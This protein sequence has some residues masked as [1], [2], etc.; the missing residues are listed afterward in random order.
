MECQLSINSPVL[1]ESQVCI[2]HLDNPQTL[3]AGLLYMPDED[4]DAGGDL[5]IYDCPKPEI[6]GKRRVK[7][8]GKAVK[9]VP[10]KP[11]T[12]VCF[13][14]SPISVHAPQKR[15]VTNKIRKF[16]NFG[17]DAAN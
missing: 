6:F 14:N 7:N 1:E 12:F 15:R 16:V 10:Y 11:N 17:I 2:A 5:E 8:P 4:D 13:K 9:V 3:W